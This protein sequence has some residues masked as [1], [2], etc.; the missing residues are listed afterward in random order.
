MSATM[1]MLWTTSPSE[2]TRT[3]RMFTSDPFTRG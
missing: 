1:G 3:M 2:E